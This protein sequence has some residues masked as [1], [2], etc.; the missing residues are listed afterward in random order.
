MLHGAGEIA[1]VRPFEEE[2]EAREAGHLKG[3][4]IVSMS[5]MSQET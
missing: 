5:T 1:F 2:M 4:Q 3:K